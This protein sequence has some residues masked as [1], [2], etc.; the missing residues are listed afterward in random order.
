MKICAEIGETE[1]QSGESNGAKRKGFKTSVGGAREAAELLGEPGALP[2]DLSL[3]PS[4]Y[5]R[6]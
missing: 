2:E 6:W 1:T 3:V 4:T 5:I